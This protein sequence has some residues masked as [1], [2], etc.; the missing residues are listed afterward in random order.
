M[1]VAR[2]EGLI[3][4]LSVPLLF[5]AVPIGT[6]N[7]YTAE[8]HSFS[9]EEIRILSALAELVH[10]EVVVREIDEL[11]QRLFARYGLMSDSV[12]SLR[13]DRTR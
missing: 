3:S 5:G 10:R 4:L 8:L 7:I 6:L 1:E 13:E 2:R 9:N 12:D 11:R